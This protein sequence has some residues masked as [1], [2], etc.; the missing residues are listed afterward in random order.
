[1]HPWL[2]TTATIPQVVLPVQYINIQAAIATAKNIPVNTPAL[3]MTWWYIYMMYTLQKI[4][5]NLRQSSML[6]L[7][8][9]AL[10]W[11]DNWKPLIHSF[12]LGLPLHFHHIC[13]SRQAPLSF[14]IFSLSLPLRSSAPIIHMHMDI[15]SI[16]IK[17]WPK[18]LVFFSAQSAICSSLNLR[19]L[20]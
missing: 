18:K 10:D 20:N 17:S 15:T 5:S 1:M 4:W 6:N 3:F 16:D 19:D 14:A 13:V 8:H 7:W 11:P 2:M 9:L 12:L